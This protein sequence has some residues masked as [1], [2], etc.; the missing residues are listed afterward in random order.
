MGAKAW[1]VA[2]LD[3]DPAVAMPD[4]NALDRH[5]TQEFAQ[6]LFPNSVLTALPDGE[7]GF[8]N[9][10]QGEV[11]VG[12]YRGARI[13]AHSSLGEDVPPSL[14]SSF[15]DPG[16]SPFAFWHA[17]HS[18]VDWCAYALWQD[19]KKVRAFGVDADNGVTID[20]GAPLPFEQ[21]FLNGERRQLDMDGNLVADYPLPFH[22]LDLSEAALVSQLGFAFEGNSTWT[23][24]P[25][26]LPI[27]RY[28]LPAERPWWKFW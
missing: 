26:D 28:A 14:G 20:E 13:V 9:P 10:P 25:Y 5:R 7:L 22:P 8:L 6:E 23:C 1:F 21:P 27:M 15:F 3:A 18:V 17:T 16:A 12:V 4:F 24:D 2:F 11:R 19:G